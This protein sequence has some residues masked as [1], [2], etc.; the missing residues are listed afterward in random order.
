MIRRCP[1]CAE[2]IPWRSRVW[3]WSP[4]ACGRCGAWMMRYVPG[5]AVALA[6]VA[7]PVLLVLLLFRLD[8]QNDWYT[9]VGFIVMFS[10]APVLWILLE[11]VRLVKAAQD[12]C[13]ACGYDLRGAQSSEHGVKCPECGHVTAAANVLRVEHPDR[14]P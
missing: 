9:F 10:F 13:A 3:A 12:H 14:T 6:I 4:W 5:W 2:P 7:A 11:R 1:Q 8:L